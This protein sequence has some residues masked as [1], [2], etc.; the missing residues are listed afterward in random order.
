MNEL[1]HYRLPELQPLWML[2]VRW[3]ERAP[4]C[5]YMDAKSAATSAPLCPSWSLLPKSMCMEN[6]CNLNFD[7]RTKRKFEAVNEW[8]FHYTVHFNPCFSIYQYLSSI[9]KLKNELEKQLTIILTMVS[10]CLTIDLIFLLVT[11]IF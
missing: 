5:F 9:I 4:Q 2:E 11:L 3:A 1:N 6:F 7:F 10:I 8:A